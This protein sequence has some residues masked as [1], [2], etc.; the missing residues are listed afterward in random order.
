MSRGVD[1]TAVRFPMEAKGATSS[2]GGSSIITSIK[3]AVVHLLRP[4]QVI[5]EFWSFLRRQRASREQPRCLLHHC[6]NRPQRLRRR[7][8]PGRWQQPLYF[9]SQFPGHCRLPLPFSKCTEETICHRKMC[10]APPWKHFKLKADPEKILPLELQLL[11]ILCLD[12]FLRI[13]LS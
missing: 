1:A 4:R 3:K 12:G 7:S 13:Y 10:F 8:F 9:F 5:F 11:C 2:D 6:R